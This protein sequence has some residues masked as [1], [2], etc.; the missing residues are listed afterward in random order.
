MVPQDFVPLNELPLTPNGKVDRRALPAPDIAR[1]KLGVHFVAA[2]DELELQLIKLWEEVLSIQPIGVYDNFFELGG[3]SLLAVRLF[4]QISDVFGQ[5]LPLATLFQTLTVEQLAGML[6]QKGWRAPWSSL[7]AIQPGGSKPPFFGI[8]GAG[9]NILMYR[10]LAQHLG[11]DQPVY[12]LQSQG[13]DGKVEP[14]T[15]ADEMAA[16]YINEI[17]AVQPRGP[18]YLGGV[19]FGGVVAFE[20]A[21]QLHAQGERV[22][23]LA[24]FNSDCPGPNSLKYLPDRKPSHSNIYPFVERVD[25]HLEDFR[26]LGSKRYLI[27][28]AR[29]IGRRTKR[30][31]WNLVG[32][33]NLIVPG[34]MDHLPPALRRVWETNLRA[35]EEYLP[36]HYPGR[37]TFFWASEGAS[38]PDRDTRSGWIELAAGGVE[39]HAVPGDHAT[40]REDP[41]VRVLA[42]K[43]SACLH[44]AQKIVGVN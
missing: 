28:R 30:K 39:F 25:I 26:R 34:P 37:I 23:L 4:A 9:A 6:R 42:E 18:Y 33:T 1:P 20:M 38:R 15:R 3:D 8:H 17:R 35:E 43:L 21:Q 32:K 41:H 24:M 44:R 13:L 14:Y 12:G 11:A 27:A 10:A 22:A 16:H 29:A 19:S 31:I 2:R 7:V 36:Q 40:M 5:D